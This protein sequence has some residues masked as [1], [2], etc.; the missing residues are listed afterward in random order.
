MIFI[1]FIHHTFI[2]FSSGNCDAKKNDGDCCTDASPCGLQEGDCDTD[3]E[4]RGSEL[5]CGLDNCQAKD[6]SWGKSTFDC[7]R[8]GIN[9]VFLQARY[10]KP[11]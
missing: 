1:L 9:N 6:P 7:C 4:C 2:Y 8:K 10:Y 5:V 11:K 3:S